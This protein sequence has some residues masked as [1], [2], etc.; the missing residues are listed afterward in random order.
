MKSGKGI[1]GPYALRTGFMATRRP[2]T[3]GGPPLL[4]LWHGFP[5]VAAH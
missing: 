1:G 4:G 2:H 5:N 3:M